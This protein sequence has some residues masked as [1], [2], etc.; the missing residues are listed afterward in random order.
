LRHIAR[1]AARI[2]SG[3]RDFS[4]GGVRLVGDDVDYRHSRTGLRRMPRQG[5]AYAAPR[6]RHNNPCA[7]QS[8]SHNSSPRIRQ[9]PPSWHELTAKRAYATRRSAVNHFVGPEWR[10]TRESLMSKEENWS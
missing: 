2:P 4:G 5:K 9:S 8:K 3:R 7:I 1:I 6:T 10:A